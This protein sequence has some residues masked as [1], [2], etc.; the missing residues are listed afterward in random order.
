MRLV[1][2]AIAVGLAFWELV[3]FRANAWL[4]GF[5]VLALGGFA[6]RRARAMVPL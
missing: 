5:F 1:L 4:A 2:P 3:G 6:A